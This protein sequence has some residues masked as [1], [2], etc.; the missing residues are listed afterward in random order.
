VAANKVRGDYQQLNEIAQTFSRQT[1]SVRTLAQSVR[2]AKTALEN[3]D[4]VGKSADTFY[5]EMDGVVLPALD[6]LVS[7]LESA[8]RTTQQISRVIRQA[9]DDAAAVLRGNG[10]SAAGTGQAAAPAGIEEERARAFTSTDPFARPSLQDSIRDMIG[11][12]TP[13]DLTPLLRAVQHASPQERWEVRNDP[14]LMELIRTTLGVS[15]RG[16]AVMAA[17]LEGQLKWSGPSGA[18]PSNGYRIRPSSDFANWILG[19]KEHVRQPSIT[20][21]SMNCWEMIMFSAY[22][23]G[24]VSYQQLVQLH[25]HAAKLGQFASMH[26]E[27]MGRHMYKHAIAEA[28]GAKDAP[29]WRPGVVPPAGSIVFFDYDG[30]GPLAHVAISLGTTNADGKVE[31]MSLW[32]GAVQRT[33]IEQLSTKITDELEKDPP[34]ITF[35]TMNIQ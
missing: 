23:M 6:R 35:G 1:D 15:D 33:T 25:E 18:D 19:G 11:S 31:V 34:K 4:W 13:V 20:T 9:E 8:S 3:G 16:A 27:A 17:L 22:Q 26:S 10:V 30:K 5:K 32:G 21:G 2:A 7:A 14:K 24:Q 29:E 12:H 28:M